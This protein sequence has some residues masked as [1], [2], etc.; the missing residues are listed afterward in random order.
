MEL[1]IK[2][3]PQTSIEYS[4]MT[5]KIYSFTY[6]GELLFDD[7]NGVERDNWKDVLIG[8]IEEY[9]V[10]DGYLR[11]FVYWLRDSG[12]TVNQMGTLVKQIMRI[13]PNLKI[14][15]M[16]KELVGIFPHLSKQEF[17]EIV[18]EK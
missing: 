17:L 12:L 6:L 15:A 4:M 1:I 18:S 14:E 3:E 9:G 5:G 10:K 11:G 16:V 2:T 8:L 7:K 13:Y